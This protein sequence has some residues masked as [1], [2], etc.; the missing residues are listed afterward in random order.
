MQDFIEDKMKQKIRR[1]SNP[2]R[3]QWLEWDYHCWIQNG[4]P[5]HG[6]NQKKRFIKDGHGHND[7]TYTQHMTI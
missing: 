1:E 7:N 5:I 4:R 3:R 2:K 6:G